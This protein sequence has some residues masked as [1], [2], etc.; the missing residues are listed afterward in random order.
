MKTRIVALLLAWFC[1][2]IGFHDYYL[3]RNIA[4]QIKIVVF[5]ASFLFSLSTFEFL[6]I[7]SVIG[8]AGVIFWT[9]IDFFKLTGLTDEEFNKLYN[10]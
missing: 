1:G 2:V 4:G 6:N 7:I 5:L 9:L 3:N 8:F 10:K